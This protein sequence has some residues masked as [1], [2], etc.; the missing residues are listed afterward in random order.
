MPAV[1]DKGI[2]IESENKKAD[3]TKL[4]KKKLPKKLKECFE[5]VDAGSI[6]RGKKAKKKRRA[7]FESP[8]H[9]FGFIQWRLSLV[10]QLRKDGKGGFTKHILKLALHTDQR[11]D[12]AWRAEVSGTLT[13]KKWT[14]KLPEG[15]NPRK[16]NEFSECVD[17]GSIVLIASYLDIPPEPIAEESSKKAKKKRRAPFE[18]PAHEFGFIQWRLSLVHQ[19]RKDGKGGFTKHILKAALHTDNRKDI[20]WRAEVSGTLTMKKWTDKLPEG[21]N[22]RKLNEYSEHFA[23]NFNQCSQMHP[24]STEFPLPIAGNAFASADGGSGDLANVYLKNRQFKFE[25]NFLLH[26]VEMGHSPLLDFQKNQSLRN[27][28]INV[29]TRKFYVNKEYLSMYSP[30]F[31]TMFTSEGF[32]EAREHQAKLEG[33]TPAAF[34]ECLHLLY[35]PLR[36]PEERYMDELLELARCYTIQ[37]LTERCEKKMLSMRNDDTTVTIEKRMQRAEEYDLL[38][39]KASLIVKTDADELLKIDTISQETRAMVERKKK[40]TAE[41]EEEKKKAKEEAKKEKKM[42][43]NEQQQ[44]K[45]GSSSAGVRGRGG[46]GIRGR[47]GRSRRGTRGVPNA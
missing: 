36:L 31:E 2:P 32:V 24:F 40:V 13:M 7:P 4:K 5:C 38:W 20:A 18:S 43:V 28:V 25:L 34:N 15:T 21:T 16:L 6:E 33:V 11:K 44:N 3:A 12:I 23:T 42:D 8:A 30:I 45:P 14:D 46:G 29:G 37:D 1:A 22:P 47:G 35:D 19:L 17:A 9:E 26:D 39:L 41:E 27:A 10:H